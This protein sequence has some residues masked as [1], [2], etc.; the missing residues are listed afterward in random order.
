MR[1]WNSFYKPTKMDL[2]VDRIARNVEVAYGFTPY[3]RYT[4]RS[5]VG[6]TA[7]A[8]RLPIGYHDLAVVSGRF[9]DDDGDDP[10]FQALVAEEPLYCPP[11][12]K[13]TECIRRLCKEWIQFPPNDD[14]LLSQ[15]KRL[16]LS[17]MHE[18]RTALLKECDDIDTEMTPDKQR[19]ALA[20]LSMHMCFRITT[21]GSY[22]FAFPIR[23]RIALMLN[24]LALFKHLLN[25]S[26]EGTVNTVR[27]LGDVLMI[28]SG[29]LLLSSAVVVGG[30]ALAGYMRSSST[31]SSSGRR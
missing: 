25:G 15:T 7:A 16:L 28:L 2:I 17:D 19:T 26:E 21:R 18:L 24:K 23:N 20:T 27:S 8:D 10:N 30:C 13:L 22:V 9:A 6:D 11:D 31:S 4:L 3:T 29:G 1:V 14:K 5:A 12:D